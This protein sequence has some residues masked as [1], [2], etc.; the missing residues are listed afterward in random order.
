MLSAPKNH[1][2]SGSVRLMSQENDTLD[3]IAQSIGTITEEQDT[4]DGDEEPAREGEKFDPE[5]M[6]R[7]KD[8]YDGG[9]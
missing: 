3:E 7:S 1:H 4:D 2:T 5:K 9:W 8:D 6:K